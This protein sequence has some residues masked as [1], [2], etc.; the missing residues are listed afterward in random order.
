MVASRMVPAGLPSRTGS[1]GWMTRS[2]M[3]NARPWGRVSFAMTCG[4]KQ[5][6]GGFAKTTGVMGTSGWMLTTKGVSSLRREVRKAGG[7]GAGGG[8][9]V[10]KTTTVMTTVR[11]K[12]ATKPAAMNA[13]WTRLL[14][15]YLMQA[16]RRRHATV[17]TASMARMMK[18]P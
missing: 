8:R 7:Q 18:V 1:D 10:Q 9:W 2:S 3:R 11:T 13:K 6:H 14:Q 12:T 15:R 5:F 17:T 16:A 4:E